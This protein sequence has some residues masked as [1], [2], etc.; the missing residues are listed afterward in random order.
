MK[1]IQSED[2]SVG[3]NDINYNF[4]ISSYGIIEGRGWDVT[5]EPAGSLLAIGFLSTKM[6]DPNESDLTG[7][8]TD[9]IADGKAVGRLTKLI[10]YRLACEEVFDENCAI[11][12]TLK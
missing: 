8:L 5:P 7:Y 2:M 11:P 12:I 6:F 4:L 9:L 10:T 1:N 3:Y